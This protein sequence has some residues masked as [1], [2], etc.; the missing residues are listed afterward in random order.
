[1]AKL[2]L[3]STW[4]VQRRYAPR[5]HWLGHRG[6]ALAA[7]RAVE[8]ARWIAQRDGVTLPNVPGRADWQHAPGLA[9]K[10]PCAVWFGAVRIAIPHWDH[11][12]AP[13]TVEYEV[14]VDG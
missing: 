10:R 11:V 6:R 12:E 7:Y 4:Y 5:D 3:K 1:V 8:Y 14:D 2:K 9:D 13:P